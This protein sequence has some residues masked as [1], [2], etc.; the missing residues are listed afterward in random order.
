MS[1]LGKLFGGTFGFLMGGPLGAILGTALGHQ[2]DKGIDDNEPIEQQDFEPGAQERV[3]TAFFVA[4]FSVMGHLS[5]SDGRVSK[6]EIAVAKKIMANMEL[7]GDM[8]ETAKKLFTN[9]KSSSFPLNEALEQFR[10][11]C[12]RR[13]NLIRMFIEIQLQ[14]AYADG[15]L[16]SAENQ[17]LLHIC[18]RLRFARFEYHRMKRIFEAQQRFNGRGYDHRYRRKSQQRQPRESTLDDAYGTLGLSSTAGDAEVKRAYRRLISQNHPDKLVAKGLPE[19]MMKVA[20]EKTQKIRSAYEMIKK[21][22]GE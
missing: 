10:V 9:G 22:R 17:L 3:Q 15:D 2:F 14:A 7:S 11:E 19:E 6:E 4:T 1:W 20:T 18:D 13:S 16:H 21:A 5:K 12:H 8:R